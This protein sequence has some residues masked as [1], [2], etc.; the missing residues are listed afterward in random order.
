MLLTLIGHKTVFIFLYL[1][2]EVF[3]LITLLMSCGGILFWWKKP[4]IVFHL[5][6]HIYLSPDSH[7]KFSLASKIT[8]DKPNEELCTWFDKLK[9]SFFFFP[10]Y[11][12][13]T[14]LFAL[15]C[16][17]F[18]VFWY[19]AKHL[20]WKRERERERKRE[21]HCNIIRSQVLFWR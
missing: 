2:Q 12:N 19:D 14:L 6:C 10:L 7:L 5:F 13:Y 8:M 3:T 17:P 18:C 1:P 15:P 16:L 4:K 21:Q 9:F 20:C 11:K